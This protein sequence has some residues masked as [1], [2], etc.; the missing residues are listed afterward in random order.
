M[1]NLP[2]RDSGVDVIDFETPVQVIDFDGGLYNHKEI[3]AMDAQWTP[4]FSSVTRVGLKTLKMKQHHI[5]SREIVWPA[6]INWQ[7]AEPQPD[8][9]P[10]SEFI[11][12]LYWTG[13][14]FVGV[15]ART[16][17]IVFDEVLDPVVEITPTDTYVDVCTVSAEF[18]P[19]QRGDIIMINSPAPSLHDYGVV[20][21]SRGESFEKSLVFA[22]TGNRWMCKFDA[23]SGPSKLQLKDT[24]SSG[25]KIDHIKIIRS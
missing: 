9:F 15:N 12:E 8:P 21:E 16:N 6:N 14:E 22:T 1:T 19:M 13:T 10:G 2:D 23:V 4:T 3:T 24:V 25:E 11:F 20:H 7:G 5:I 18:V 17:I